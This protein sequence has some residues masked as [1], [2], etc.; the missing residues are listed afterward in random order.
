[1]GCSFE[2]KFATQIRRNWFFPFS[3]GSFFGLSLPK[4]VSLALSD[5]IR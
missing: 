5:A 3:L 1:M 4:S 2:T